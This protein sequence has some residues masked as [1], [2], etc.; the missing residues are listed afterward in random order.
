MLGYTD[1][2]LGMFAADASDYE[3]HGLAELRS[4]HDRFEHSA[5]H[6]I[7]ITTAAVRDRLASHLGSLPKWASNW[8]GGI[9][10]GHHP[11]LAFAF[12]IPSF[13]LLYKIHK[14]KLGMRPI[15][16]NHVWVTQPLAL[17]LAAL[18]LPWILDT[19]GTVST[20][21]GQNGDKS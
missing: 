12:S 9:L 10:D 6:A 7:A 11:A 14:S 18:L 15:T 2:N 1:K 4:T 3:A 21:A 5:R 8:I 16:G 17:L 20:V 19:L 13:R